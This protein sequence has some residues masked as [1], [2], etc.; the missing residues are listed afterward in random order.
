M[1]KK[2]CKHGRRRRDQCKECGGSGICEHG[3]RRCRCKECGGS[4][5]CEHDRRRERCKECGGSQICEHNRLRNNCKEC[6]GSSICEHNK[7]RSACKE[8]GTACLFLKAGFTSE[9]IKELGAIKQCQYP[10]CGV[11]VNSSSKGLN[12][13]HAHDGPKHNTK[14]NR[15][16]YRG[17]ICTGHNRL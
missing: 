1:N 5:F 12:S 11:L 7:Q 13:D 6:G 9:E 14:I 8:C 17:E 2:K 4:S 15:E 16:N 3:S 10:N